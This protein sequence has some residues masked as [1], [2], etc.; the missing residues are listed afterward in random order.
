MLYKLR[1]DANNFTKLLHVQY[2][3]SNNGHSTTIPIIAHSDSDPVCTSTH[4]H[5]FWPHHVT[6]GDNINTL[7]KCHHYITVSIQVYSQSMS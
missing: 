7:I 3:H 4:P 6:N 1:V 5:C 2:H